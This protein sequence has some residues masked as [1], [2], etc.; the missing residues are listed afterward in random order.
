[1][2][3]DDTHRRVT[4][5]AFLNINVVIV[6]VKCSTDTSVTC[7]DVSAN[8]EKKKIENKNAKFIN[9]ISRKG[10]NKPSFSFFIH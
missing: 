8:N 4:A 10:E 1:M 2:Y 5:M 6:A 7:V 9:T 3:V